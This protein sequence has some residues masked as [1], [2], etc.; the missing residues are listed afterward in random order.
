MGDKQSFS[1][2]GHTVFLQFGDIQSFS[3]WGTYCPTSVG[4]HELGDI[5]SFV[6]S[7]TYSSTSVGGHTVLLPM[8]T[9]SPSAGGTYICFQFGN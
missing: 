7:G 9:Y 2:W 3:H 8:G 4:L 1:V 6:R 5:Q